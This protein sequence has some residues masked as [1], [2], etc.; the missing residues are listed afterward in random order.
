MNKEELNQTKVLVQIQH[1][2]LYVVFDLFPLAEVTSFKFH[3]L[4]PG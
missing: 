3:L 2:N 1:P 4:F